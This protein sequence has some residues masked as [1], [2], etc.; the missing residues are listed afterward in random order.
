MHPF[1]RKYYCQKVEQDSESNYKNS[2]LQVIVDNEVKQSPQS[3]NDQECQ[4]LD[5]LEILTFHIDCIRHVIHLINCFSI[6]LNSKLNFAEE[7]NMIK[8]DFKFEKVSTTPN[9]PD[10][11]LNAFYVKLIEPTIENLIKGGTKGLSVMEDTETLPGFVDYSRE[12]T[13]L[14]V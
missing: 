7:L 2:I 14:P 6:V 13:Y 4:I 11:F 12:I 3:F 10:L 5:T 8:L 1:S 9:D